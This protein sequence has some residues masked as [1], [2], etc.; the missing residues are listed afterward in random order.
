MTTFYTYYAHTPD[1][2]TDLKIGL[3]ELKRSPG[4]IGVKIALEEAEKLKTILGFD[5]PMDLTKAIPQKILRK[6]YQLAV[7]KSI[8]EFKSH[9]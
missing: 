1:R 3:N 5:L 9:P 2:S 4:S 8:W 6:D 7:S